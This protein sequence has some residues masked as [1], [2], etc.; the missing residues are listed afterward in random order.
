MKPSPAPPSPSPTRLVLALVVGLLTPAALGAC[1]MQKLTGNTMVTYTTDHVFTY[2]MASDDLNAA[3]ELGVSMGGF[4]ESFAAVDVNPDK[5][6]ITSQVAAGMCAEALAW[7]L[8]LERTRALGRGDATGAQDALIREKEAHRLAAT[9]NYAAYQRALAA[10]GSPDAGCPKFGNRNDEVLYMLGLSAG[11]LALLH[12]QN[13]DRSA[14][15]P[16]DVPVLV[17]RGAACLDPQ[18]WWGVPLALRAAVW[19]SVPGL[20]G[21]RDPWAALHEAATLGDEAGVSMARALLVQSARA[22]GQKERMCAALAAQEEALRQTPRADP[23]RLLDRYG[24]VMMRFEND[25]TWTQERGH[26]APFGHWQC[27]AAPVVIDDADADDLLEGL[28]GPDEDEPTPVEPELL[29]DAKAEA[30]GA[31]GAEAP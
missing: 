8:A 30:E 14:G 9:R 5:A 27:P 13:A 28:F 6:A 22:A 31:P 20:G 26:R 15:V 24:Q 4:L 19:L 7:E 21:D 11:A 29:D 17:E 25:I 23:W 10:Y 2:L 16:M 18:R 3:C 1:S 12:D